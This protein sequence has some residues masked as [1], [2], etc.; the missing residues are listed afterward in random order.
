[1]NNYV[2]PADFQ[3]S[4]PDDKHCAI[5]TYADGT[6][7]TAPVSPAAV[8][9][10]K[11]ILESY[12]LATDKQTVHLVRDHSSNVMYRLVADDETVELPLSFQGRWTNE[13]SVV[14]EV[15][16]RCLRHKKGQPV[17]A[18][19]TANRCKLCKEYHAKTEGCRPVYLP[20]VSHCTTLLELHKEGLA[21]GISNAGIEVT[22]GKDY[23]ILSAVSSGIQLQCDGESA[24]AWQD[25]GDV[26]CTINR[27]SVEFVRYVSLWVGC[28]EPHKRELGFLRMADAIDH[29][30]HYIGAAS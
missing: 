24:Y 2:N 20:I 11:P 16:G 4:H 18:F 17:D 22:R 25:T 27:P 23:T 26:V 21:T 6:V 5:A 7:A 28:D 19:G 10:C 1:M 15:K 12:A 8:K 13:K 9:A 29:I 3:R 30:H 14:R